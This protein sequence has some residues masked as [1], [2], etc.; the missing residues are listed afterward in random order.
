MKRESIIL[1]NVVFGLVMIGVIAVYSAGTARSF[2]EGPLNSVSDRYLWGQLFRVGLGLVGLF[3][4][5]HF[6]YHFFRNRY[7]LWLIAGTVLAMLVLVVV[8]AEARLGARRWLSI[9][10]FSL[11]PS[12]F[13]KLAVVLV[14]AVKISENQSQMKYFFKGFCPPLLLAGLF[15]GLVILEKDIGTPVIIGAVALLMLVMGGASWW[16]PLVSVGPAAGIV[17]GYIWLNP[18]AQQRLYSWI[19]PWQYPQDEGWQLIQSFRAFA[20]GGLLGQGA[21]AGQQKLSYLPEAESDFVFAMWGEEMGL[22]G[23]VLVV[24]LFAV[25][26]IVAIRIAI[27][28][29]DLLG[30]L[31]ASGIATLLTLQAGLSMGVTTGLLPTKGLTL[32]FISAGGTAL[33]VNLTLVGILIN[34]ASQAEEPETR[35]GIRHGAMGAAAHR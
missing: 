17:G 27:C 26:M 10:G 16:H 4:A 5:A 15:A 20:Q 12:D 8:L 33:I 13:A 24:L 19:D 23:T 31:L 34:I 14:L 7:L 21:G 9:G 22:V 2:A 1:L 6:N 3:A 35:K 11:Q 32:P 18:H 29:P 30:A 28:A 25:F